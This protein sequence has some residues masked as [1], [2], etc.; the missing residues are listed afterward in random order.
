MRCD[1]ENKIRIKYQRG[2][3]A[4]PHFHRSLE[5]NFIIKG[6]CRICVGERE[7]IF[8]AGE[9]AF[10]PSC[11]PHFV[12]AEAEA[13]SVTL[14]VPCDSCKNFGTSNS[15]FLFFALD[16][17]QYNE[18]LF[19]YIAEM[20]K[21]KNNAAVTSGFTNVILG[22]VAEKYPLLLEKNETDTRFISELA[23]YLESYYQEDLTLESVAAHFGFSKFYFSRIFNAFFH[24][25]FKT[26]INR[27]RLRH[28]ERDKKDSK[29][30]T[31]AIISSGF[32]SL[33]AYYQFRKREAAKG[34]Q[35]CFFR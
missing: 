11:F 23:A 5:L 13:E 6:T 8:S 21:Y 28:I 17:V 20:E 35:D 4:L 26:Y 14:I 19:S 24:C 10:V 12:I 34:S 32:G 1:A 22:M 27:I 9:I 29:N 25:N 7:R 16:D 2:V 31:D 33:S 30:L 3:Y 18:K 15:S